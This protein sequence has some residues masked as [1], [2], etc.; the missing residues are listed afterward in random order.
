MDHVARLLHDLSQPSAYPFPVAQVE[1][2]QTHISLVFLAGEWVYKVKKPVKLAFLDFSTVQLRCK[3]CAEEV[4]LNQRLAPKVY[5]GVVPVS[6]TPSGLKFEGDGEVVD[7]AVKMVRLP[8]EATLEQRLLRGE[9]REETVCALGERLASFHARADVG[10]FYCDFPHVARNARENLQAAATQTGV[11]LSVSVLD[12]LLHWQEA[13][14]TLQ[15]PRITARALIGKGRDTHGDLHLDHIYYFPDQP[16]PEELVIIDCIE[17]NKAFRSADP[18][19]DMAFTYM[20]LCYHGRRDLANLFAD[21]YFAA[22]DDVEGRKLLPFYSAYRAMVRGKVEGITLTEKEIPEAERHHAQQQARAH[23][24]LALGELAEPKEK[25]CL[26]LIGGLPGS[27]KSTLAQALADQ[28]N[29]QVLRSD[30]IRKELARQVPTRSDFGTGLYTPEWDERVYLECLRRVEAL[31]WEGR[32]VILDASFRAEHFRTLFLTAAVRWGVPG[33]LLF[34]EAPLAML[35]QRVTQRQGDASDADA[36]I[37]AAAAA[38]WEAPVAATLRQVKVI[39][40]SQAI[41]QVV[42]QALTWLKSVDLV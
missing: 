7:W 29:F 15:A 25:P 34:C 41:P 24:L 17:F 2:R 10:N 1:V 39:D 8:E 26:L 3:F 5:Q 19:A 23:W 20:D 27:G 12:H 38:R 36:A 33:W 16:P 30:V 14:L 22:S 31:L 4:R 21:A 37:C 18:V 11:C 35:Q 6:S 40:T 9:L 13:H 32:R 28:A 42:E